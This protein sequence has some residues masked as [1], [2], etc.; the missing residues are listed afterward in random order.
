MQDEKI[1]IIKRMAITVAFNT[2]KSL[3]LSKLNDESV[4]EAAAKVI[5]ILEK[6]VGVLIDSNPNNADQVIDIW[7]QEKQALI[8]FGLEQFIDLLNEKIQ[9][10]ELKAVL[11][12]NAESLV[13]I[14]TS[15]L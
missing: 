12:A 4:K 10:D 1:G 15:E 3:V 14:A 2:I 9:D 5:E 13:Q 11:V 7:K 8:G 6:I